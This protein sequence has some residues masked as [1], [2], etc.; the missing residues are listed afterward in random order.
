MNFHY[1]IL[2]SIN[3]IKQ[4]E[5]ME[6]SKIIKTLETFITEIQKIQQTKIIYEWIKPIPM[7]IISNILLII[8]YRITGSI[9]KSEKR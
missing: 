9:K 1:L 3:L 7:I 5:L 8:Y 4:S 2:K 6:F